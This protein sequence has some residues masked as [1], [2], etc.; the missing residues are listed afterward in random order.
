MT[1]KLHDLL[2]N[3]GFQLAFSF[4]PRSYAPSHDKGAAQHILGLLGQGMD[5]KNYSDVR[6]VGIKDAFPD[7][8][9]DERVKDRFLIYV[10]PKALE[11]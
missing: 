2:I 8:E 4:T 11:E 9:F 6:L 3:E 10:K 7:E 5:N 1:Q